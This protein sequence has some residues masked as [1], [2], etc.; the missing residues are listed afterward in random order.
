M[1]VK[2]LPKPYGTR[3]LI[4][5]GIASIVIV[6]IS[7]AFLNR[8]QSKT[9]KAITVADTE[10]QIPTINALGRLEP[11][12]EVIQVSAPSSFGQGSLVA[13]ILIKEGEQVEANQLIAILDERDQLQASLNEA[14]EQVKVARSRLAQVKAGAKQGEIVARQATISRLQAELQGEMATQQATINRLD[15]ERQGQKEILQATVARIQAEKRNAQRE[16]ERY[17]ILFEQGVIS[18]QEV[19]DRRLTAETSTQELLES[20]ATQRKTIITLEQEINQAKAQLSK[21]IATLKAQI[22]EAK[23]QL[24]QTIEI[25]PTDVANAQAEVDSAI[26]SV[27]RI[28]A[29]LDSAYIR[30]P[31]AGRILA[32][33]TKAG[34]TVGNKGIVEMAQTDQ[35]YAI[36][37]IYESDIGKIKPGQTVIVTSPSQTFNGEL[38]GT[39]ESIAWQVAKKDILDSDPTA[40]TDARVIEVKVSLESEAS[41]KVA[42]FTNLQVNVEIDAI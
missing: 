1:Q 25:R 4:A 9:N 29:E 13:E 31:K 6:G 30:A 8:S 35:M 24:D 21:T 34:E 11:R 38:K 5:L 20:Q 16:V 2:L 36:A 15:A 33:N 10:L 41:Q 27:K 26:A 23:G 22:N 12:G 37:E 28:Q 18:S 40:A 42:N 39:V 3:I 19:D 32:I 7:F 17:E 14:E